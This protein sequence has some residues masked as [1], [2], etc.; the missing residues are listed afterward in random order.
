MSWRRSEAGRGWRVSAKTVTDVA[1]CVP[2]L[3]GPRPAAAVGHTENRLA[4][5]AGKKTRDVE[6]PTVRDGR[7][8][9]HRGIQGIYF[10]RIRGTETA[11]RVRVCNFDQ[12]SHE[13][14]WMKFQD[15]VNKA[16]V[17]YACPVAV[18]AATADA[19]WHP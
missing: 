16:P 12:M 6:N 2:C 17:Q 19:I 13:D 18:G 3:A 5:L 15:W 7:V 8:Y 1:R 10:D 14:V 4:I 9:A 11:N